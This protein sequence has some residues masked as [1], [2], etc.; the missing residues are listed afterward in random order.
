MHLDSGGVPDGSGYT[1]GAVG[2]WDSSFWV[3]YS[4][5]EIASPRCGPLGTLRTLA[6]IVEV[7][8]A[9]LLDP[10]TLGN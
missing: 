2:G 4:E 5:P 9:C 8:K 7:L 3:E 10:S 1:G 6:K